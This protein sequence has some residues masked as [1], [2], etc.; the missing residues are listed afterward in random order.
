M[1]TLPEPQLPRLAQLPEQR[2]GRIR[3]VVD[4]VLPAVDRGRFAA[5]CIAAEPFE[6][7]GHC[8]AD[9]HDVLQARL[10]WRPEA[11]AAWTEVVMKAL[12]ND[13]WKASFVPPAPG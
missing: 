11:E 7:T 5:K 1:P 3:A 8:F 9:G 13:V 10:C 12:P 2:D 6:V 4:A